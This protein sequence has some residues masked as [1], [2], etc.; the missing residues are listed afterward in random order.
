VLGAGVAG[1]VARNLPNHA[2]R[3]ETCDIPAGVPIDRWRKAHKR[4]NSGGAG[5]S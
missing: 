4:N 5:G 1:K 2:F 3:Y